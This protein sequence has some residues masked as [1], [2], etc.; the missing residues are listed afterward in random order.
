M[1]QG[2]AH[3]QNRPFH[4]QERQNHVGIMRFGFDH[5][6]LIRLDDLSCGCEGRLSHGLEAL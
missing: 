3:R 4:V 2:R 1:F 6:D 5:W